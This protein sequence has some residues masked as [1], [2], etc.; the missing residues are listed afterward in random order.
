MVSC[1]KKND[2]SH[3][4][5]V[6]V[7]QIIEHKSLNEEYKG[8]RDG[9]EEAGYVDGKNIKIV[10]ENAQ[11]NIATAAQ[12]A[13]K[14]QSIHPDVVVAVSTPSAQAIINGFT[15]HSHTPIIFSAV[16]DPID[17]K[18]VSSFEGNRQEWVTGIT[19]HIP[20]SA[21]LDMI[22]TLLPHLKTLG[23]IYNPGE[24]NSV[25]SVSELKKVAAEYGIALV[26]STSSKTSD[27]VTAV[28]NLVGKVDAI[29]I[30]NDNTAVS[31]M[32]SIV[33]VGEKNKLPVFAGDMGSFEDGVVAVA[34]YDRFMLGKKVAEYVVKVLKGAHSGD[35]PV[36]QNH[37]IV[38]YINL[39]AAIRMGI[40]VDPSKLEGF[41]IKK[42]HKVR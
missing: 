29:Y 33:Q 12:I 38:R 37:P 32:R 8:L 13:T 16:T 40:K 1:A 34:A 19:D 35:L 39:E 14:F 17:A 41:S 9:L 21:P 20:A 27:V 22:K 11:G 15:Q 3:K 2:T 36:A 4:K 23:V 24:Q 30:P 25:K 31:A 5:I 10:F 28:Q 18:L 7:T 6:A 42:V 26:E